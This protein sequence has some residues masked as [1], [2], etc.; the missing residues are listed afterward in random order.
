MATET[1]AAIVDADRRAGRVRPRLRS[2]GDVYFRVRSYAGYGKLSNRRPRN[3]P[4]RGGGLAEPQGGARST[5]RSGRRHKAGRGHQPGTR[6]GAR[7]AP[8][9]TSSA[10]RWPRQELGAVL[11]RSTAA[12]PTSSSPTTRTRSPSPGGRG[13]RFA[14]VWMHN[15]MVESTRREDVEIGG[16]HLPALRGAGSL[17]ARGAWSPI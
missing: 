15:G 10:R 9:G 8:A 11:R 5:S 14:R 16:Q 12:A 13:G 6:P 17:R 4:G 2:G 3:G 7:A 1:I